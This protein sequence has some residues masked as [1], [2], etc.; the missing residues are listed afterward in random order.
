MVI[1]K[2]AV[3]FQSTV[4]SQIREIFYIGRLDIER[5]IVE[6]ARVWY[7]ARDAPWV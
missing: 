6:I 7:A 1:A 4:V 2:R 3:W 5:Q